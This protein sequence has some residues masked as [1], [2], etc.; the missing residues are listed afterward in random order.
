MPRGPPKSLKCPKFDHTR[1][2]EN[3]ARIYGQV[4]LLGFMGAV[5]SGMGEA[6]FLGNLNVAG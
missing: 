2:I 1:Q 5:A 3:K 6:F 4:P